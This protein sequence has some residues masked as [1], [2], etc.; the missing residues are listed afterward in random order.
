MEKKYLGITGIT[1]FDEVEKILQIW[2]NN[3]CY[4]FD[5]FL[6]FL[7]KRNQFSEIDHI[8][9]VEN[10]RY[11][12]ITILRDLMGKATMDG[13]KKIVH[14]STPQL[15][16]LYEDLDCL[17]ENVAGENIDGIQLNIKN[18]PAFA[19]NQFLRYWN[20]FLILQLNQTNFDNIEKLQAQLY[21]YIL[22]DFSGGHGIP[23]N[24]QDIGK[25]I[26]HVMNISFQ[27]RVGIAG[28]IGP[29]N[30]GDLMSEFRGT[31][32]DSETNLRTPDNKHLDLAK[33]EQ[34]IKTAVEIEKKN[35]IK[36]EYL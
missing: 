32:F 2:E 21:K 8:D 19:I 30:I 3:K 14:F 28:G 22:I 16:T 15:A 7:V 25:K 26:D 1:A 24:I 9:K 4:E 10:P 12:D 34:Y 33:V 11:V 20:I 13:I 5:L 35:K 6:G 23:L 31:S 17:M 18:P 29:H 36:I 27:S